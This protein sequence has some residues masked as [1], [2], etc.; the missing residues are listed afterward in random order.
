MPKIRELI[1]KQK[2]VA[3]K[4]KDTE[5]YKRRREFMRETFNYNKT[6]NINTMATNLHRYAVLDNVC[7]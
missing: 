3:A 2:K 5:V 7:F 4:F 6:T 1:K